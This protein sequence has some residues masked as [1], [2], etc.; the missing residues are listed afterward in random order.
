MSETELLSQLKFRIANLE[1][2][3][4]DKQKVID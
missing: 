4:S 1:S 2:N 3:I